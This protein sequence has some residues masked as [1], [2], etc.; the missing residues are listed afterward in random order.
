MRNAGNER[1]IS[2]ASLFISALQLMLINGDEKTFFKKLCDITVCCLNEV[3]VILW[4]KWGEYGWG[5]CLRLTEFP[6]SS[7]VLKLVLFVV[8]APSFLHGLR[9]SFKRE[10]AR[11]VS[12][13]SE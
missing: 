10:A 3:L 2:M 12:S 6:E 11:F 1:L 4:H 5:C 9:F 13:S 8:S 7:L